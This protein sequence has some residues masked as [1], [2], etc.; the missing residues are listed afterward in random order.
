MK[1]NANDGKEWKDFKEKG[2]PSLGSKETCTAAYHVGCAR[3]GGLNHFGVRRVY[4]FPGDEE[5]AVV[6]NTFCSLH[7]ED[8]D[9]SHQKKLKLAEERRRAERREDYEK[10]R[11][12]ELRNAPPPK[13]AHQIM[14][15]DMA[16]FVAPIQ[17]EETRQKAFQKRKDHWK[18]TLNLPPK[19]FSDAW[20]IAKK[21]LRDYIANGKSL[22]IQRSPAREGS[23]QRV[24]A[25]SQ[26]PASARRE[27]RILEA[28]RLIANQRKGTQQGNSPSKRGKSLKNLAS[29]SAKR[30]RQES[31]PT[32]DSDGEEGGS[33]WREAEG[34][35]LVESNNEEPVTFSLVSGLCRPLPQGCLCCKDEMLVPELFQSL[36]RRKDPIDVGKWD[37]DDSLS[38]LQS[39]NI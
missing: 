8:V 33:E 38:D 4:F 35:G 28:Q 7:A 2:H 5:T 25:Q 13:P 14:F 24:V 23:T 19:Q 31:D 27:S 1:C 36:P 16:R 18:A 26:A 37:L 30:R 6:T 39:N 11:L 10:R 12:E 21:N 3:W 15:E 20:K 9:Y 29:I 34:E 22:P 17:C 32:A